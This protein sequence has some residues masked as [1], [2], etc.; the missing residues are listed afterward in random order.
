MK[1]VA[2]WNC[3]G[4]TDGVILDG[5]DQL[6]EH[7][8]LNNDTQSNWSYYELGERVAI[9]FSINVKVNKN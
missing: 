8:R 1:Y 6:E 3:G 2:L 4:T 7:V 9:S 5:R